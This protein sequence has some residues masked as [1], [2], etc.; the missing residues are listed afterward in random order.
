MVLNQTFQTFEEQPSLENCQNF[1][2]LHHF[3]NRTQK[4]HLKEET[5]LEVTRS[6]AGNDLQS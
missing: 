2:R 5:H 3:Y 1:L 6:L 4:A